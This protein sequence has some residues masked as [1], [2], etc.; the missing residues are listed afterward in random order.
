MAGGRPRDAGRV[1]DRHARLPRAGAGPRPDRRGH[2]RRHLRPRRHALLPAHRARC[3][4][5]ART[6]P[7]SCIKHCTDPPPALLRRGR[8]RRRTSTRSSSGHG[9]A[10]GTAAADAAAT[11]SGAAPFCQPARGA[12][13]RRGPAS[14]LARRCRPMPVPPTEPSSAVLFRLPPQIVECRPHPPPRRTAGFPWGYA[15]VGARRA[16]G[17]SD[18]RLRALPRAPAAARAAARF[19]HH[20]G[21]VG[22]DSH[23]EA[24]RRDVPDGLARDASRAASPTRGRRTR[25]RSRG[26]YSSRP[27]RSRRRSTSR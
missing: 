23:G 17:R 8:M 16:R 26:R 13:A 1:R 21:A 3:P 24:R 12:R 9:E 5:T 27:G 7:R 14:R 10:A 2:P 11:G 18:S 6:R 20:L 22:R 25:S 19:V 4:T 15:L